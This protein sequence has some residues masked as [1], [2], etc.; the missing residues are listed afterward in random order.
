MTALASSDVTVTEYTHLNNLV[1]TGNRRVNV[2]DIAFGD[3]TLTYPSGGVPL[4]DHDKFGVFE[5]IDALIL[6]MPPADCYD[7][8]YDRTNHK[9]RIYSIG[10]GMELDTAAAPDAA[11]LRA[12]VVGF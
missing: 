9:I 5:E 2:V 7:Y 11:T 4:P 3:S 10:S 8:R 1:P 12:L 6:E